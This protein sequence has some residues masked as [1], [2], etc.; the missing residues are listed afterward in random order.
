MKRRKYVKEFD[1]AVSVMYRQKEYFLTAVY[2]TRLKTLTA[3]LIHKESGRQIVVAY[4]YLQEFN[5][6][7]ENI[8]T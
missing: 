3:I 7:L 4:D 1:P 2:M 8:N 5:D 6:H